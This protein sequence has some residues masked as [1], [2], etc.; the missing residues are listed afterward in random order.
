LTNPFQA[1]RFGILEWVR[2][3]LDEAKKTSSL[4]AII[5][6]YDVNGATPMAWAAIGKTMQLQVQTLADDIIRVQTV[7]QMW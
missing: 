1:C 6:E 7:M 3:L 5:D 4:K 2:S